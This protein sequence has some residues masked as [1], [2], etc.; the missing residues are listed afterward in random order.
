MA[1]TMSEERSVVGRVVA[2]WRYPVK[3]MAAQALAAVDVSWHGVAGDRRWAFVRPGLERSGFP[4]LTIRERSDLWRFDPS[5]ADPARPEVSATHVR[6]PS[7]ETFDV[8]DPAL[9]ELL[10]PGA[11]V[12]RQNRGVFDAAPLSLMT[13]TDRRGARIERRPSVVRAAALS[14][15]PPRRCDRR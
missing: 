9:T 14:P 10:A 3:S 6:T 12:V 15:E 2:I 1:L 8:T 13:T 5:F 4:W 7:G 11:R